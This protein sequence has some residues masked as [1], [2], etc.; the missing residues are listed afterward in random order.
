MC[1]WRDD[2]PQTHFD[3][4]LQCA[5][6]NASLACVGSAAEQL[7]LERELLAGLPFFRARIS[8]LYIFFRGTGTVSA[9]KGWP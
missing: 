5:E 1:Y 4:A 2:A 6:R 8:I 9:S 7:F 3:C